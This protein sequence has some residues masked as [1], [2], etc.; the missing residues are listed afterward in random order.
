MK[1]SIISLF[2]LLFV[3]A[4]VAQTPS[5]VGLYNTG[6]LVDGVNPYS[7]VSA[8]AGATYQLYVPTDNVWPINGPWVD[9]TLS[10]KWLAVYSGST[11]P[12]GSVPTV[13]AGDYTIRLNFDLG[14]YDPSTVAFGFAAAADNTLAVSLNGIN[15]SNLGSAVGDAN[16]GSLNNYL[17]SVDGATLQTGANSLD[18]RLTNSSGASGNPAGLYVGFTS[19]NGAVI[20]EPSTYALL[21]GVATLAVVAW[22][23][24]SAR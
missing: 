6:T 24:R 7:L 10:T 14:A 4:A 12:T 1:S 21:L 19:F 11:V 17:Y 8:P 18:F 16:Y 9:N 20:P 22:R 5:S 15:L 2:S 13:A 23:R 3:T